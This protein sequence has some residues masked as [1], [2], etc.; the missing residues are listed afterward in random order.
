[1]V[2]QIIE[3]ISF[4]DLGSTKLSPNPPKTTN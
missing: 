2:P 3:T 1:V 4:V